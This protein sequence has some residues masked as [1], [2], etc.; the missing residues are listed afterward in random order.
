MKK[1]KYWL[2]KKGC[3]RN[4]LLPRPVMLLGKEKQYFVTKVM[5]KLDKL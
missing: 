2:E 1:R 5:R 4:D 3:C